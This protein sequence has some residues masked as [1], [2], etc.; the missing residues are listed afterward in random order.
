MRA[1][2]SSTR[3]S[4]EVICSA[5]SSA[6]SAPCGSR[7]PICAA[8]STSRSAMYGAPLA[9][10][11]SSAS[12]MTGATIP[13]RR[14]GEVGASA[15][16]S[17][18]ALARPTRAPAATTAERE[19]E[20]RLQCQSKD[21]A[22]IHRTGMASSAA[23]SSRRMARRRHRVVA[24]QPTPAIQATSSSR[25][26]MPFSDMISR[27]TLWASSVSEVPMSRFRFHQIE[28]PP[29]PW[30]SSRAVGEGRRGLAP[31]L[32]P[33]ARGDAQQAPA[34]LGD[35]AARDAL[36]GVAQLLLDRP[37]L[38]ARRRPGRPGPRAPRRPPRR[39]APSAGRHS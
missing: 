23:I 39:D 38:R 36:D 8:R 21:A 28:K 18:Y 15:H 3:G 10:A 13:T 19:T 7:T 30:P 6:S 24:A 31:D 12:T 17:R 20:G 2:S 1:R 9:P 35:V 22:T 29:A 37:G 27:N 4:R 11:P 14:T 5:R 16:S 34:A 33:A 32:H 25:P 26:R